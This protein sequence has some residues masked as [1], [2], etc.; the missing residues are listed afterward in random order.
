MQRPRRKDGP[1]PAKH[2]L[3]LFLL[4]EDADL[5]ECVRGAEATDSFHVSDVGVETDNLFVRAAGGTTPSWVGLLAPHADGSLT[6]VRNS[7]SAAILFIGAADRIFALTFGY[8]RHLLEPEAVVQDFGLKVVLNTVAY[9]QIKSVD[10]RT[11]DELTLHTR[12]DVSRD[13]SFGAFG[14]DVATDLVR[15]V[16]GSTTRDGLNGRLT[17]SDALALNIRVDVP[18]LPE[19]ASRL[20]S[21]YQEQGYK[22]HF[23]FIDH[24]RAVKDPTVIEQLDTLLLEAIHAREIGNL[25]LAVPEPLNWID[26]AGFRFSSDSP[27][28]R[29]DID[30]DPR[31][32]R[33]LLGREADALTIDRLKGDQVQ[34]MRA[35]DDSEKLQGWSVYRCIVFEVEQANQ[36][37][38]LSAGQWY[39]ISVDFKDDVYADV[40]SLPTLAMDLPEADFGT[41]EDRYIEKVATSTG[42]LTLDRQLARDSV[43]DPVEICDLL[44]P[45]RQ[46]L[47]LKKRGKSSTLSHLFSQGVT[48]AE[49]LLQSAEFRAEARQIAANL[50][51]RFGDVLPDGRPSRDDYEVAYVVITRSRRQDAPLTLPFFSLVSLRAAAQRLQGFGYRVSVAA[52]REA[53]SG[54][55]DEPARV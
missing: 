36:L 31:I 21:A 26:V 30:A 24:L 54:T 32:S 6:H 23:D 40:R 4:K 42:A 46:L 51:P 12:R 43:P 44:T 20:L 37:Y 47:H 15:A 22:E 3:T 17:G 16:T 7:S 9:N 27:E 34:A 52:V 45:E 5:D 10:A 35:S 1:L 49:L 41:T 25:H 55:A 33:Y 53:Q 38:T 14:L 2:R 18:G 28:M 48:S 13:S 11:V 29:G 50:D 39:R 19:L 8:G